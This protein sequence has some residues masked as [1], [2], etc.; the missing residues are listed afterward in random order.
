MGVTRPI[1][2]NRQLENEKEMKNRRKGII[3]NS[4]KRKRE[5]E[6]E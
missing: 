5:R 3:D 1:K 4:R 2:N 6:R